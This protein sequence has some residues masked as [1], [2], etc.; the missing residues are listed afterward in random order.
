MAIRHW[1]MLGLL[2]L[3]NTC[4]A[5]EDIVEKLGI[6]FVQE[7]DGE[8]FV[9]LRLAP[10]QWRLARARAKL[11]GDDTVAIALNARQLLALRRIV[12][13][14]H[15]WTKIV[16]Q[17]SSVQV[18]EL[19]GLQC[20]YLV[21]AQDVLWRSKHKGQTML[22]MY[23]TIEESATELEKM[24]DKMTF[25]YQRQ[26]VPLWDVTEEE[27]WLLVNANIV[28]VDKGKI[29]QERAMLVRNRRIAKLLRSEEVAQVRQEY[30]VK[31]E[32]DVRD[33]YLIPGLSD[34]HCHL[35][36]ISEF[37][38]GPF[39]LRCF[40]GQRMKNSEETIKQ[41]CTFV[42]DCGG[43][44]PKIGYLKEEI[45]ADRL[46]GPKIMASNGAVSPKGGMWDV[47]AVKNRLGHIIFGGKL[48][49][50]AANDK[51]ILEAMRELQESGNDF[52]K[53]Y[54]EAKPLYGGKENSVYNMFTSEQALLIKN[55]ASQYGKPA[56]G[57]AMFMKG[58][59]LLID[60][61]FNT[62]EHLN[63]DEPYGLTDAKKMAA[64]GVAIVPT[65]SLGCYLSMNCGD[66]GF[67]DNQDVL[68]FQK[69]RHDT[70]ESEVARYVI[71]E[72][73]K[74]YTKFFV[75]L[76]RP[77]EERSMPMIGQVYPDR[78]HN[79]AR[80]APQSL[81]NFREAG[82]RVGV[83]TDGGT[84]ITFCGNVAKE[85][86]LLCRYGYSAAQVLR[87]A[88][89]GNMEI[90]GMDKELGAIKAGNYADLVV[91]AANPLLSVEAVAQVVQVF[92]N[93][94]LYYQAK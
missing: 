41:G 15:E 77:Q 31:K 72:L 58:I 37:E 16:V 81:A 80:L 5:Q 35:T 49:W 90:V 44:L 36:L 14:A 9:F 6:A 87:M 94:R 45:A 32:L 63:C 34:I 74:N 71:P 70:Y 88:T 18:K 89:L 75:W 46:L 67:H 86:A 54:F 11:G 79:F 33:R 73:Q 83:G 78:V 93:G 3:V 60:A 48:L 59:R 23:G 27:C 24:V 1:F 26:P 10:T 66:K 68:Y 12:A 62:I 29:R 2:C 22:T 20:H 61:G 76:A 53:F 19:K 64:R 7:R 84:G 21:L 55:Q 39:D 42:R 85:M 43:A 51:D 52:F 50:F 28:D 69:L 65:L 13:D 4:M 40:D 17:V 92:K 47:G 82:T 56:A 30:A 57:H 8:E 91:L 25:H 38:M